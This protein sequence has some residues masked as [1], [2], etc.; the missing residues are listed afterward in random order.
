MLRRNQNG[1]RLNLGFPI[2]VASDLEVEGKDKTIRAKRS[3]SNTGKRDKSGA[4]FTVSF[5]WIF[6]LFFN[7][8]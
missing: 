1:F 4:A 6:R 3:N 8:K 7:R 2:N 5:Y